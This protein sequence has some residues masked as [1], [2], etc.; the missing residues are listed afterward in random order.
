ML[1]KYIAQIML[2]TICL[3]YT[4]Y[5]KYLELIYCA[6]DYVNVKIS[7]LER[8]KIKLLEFYQ[9]FDEFIST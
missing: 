5:Q 9:F 7:L 3:I 1:Q 6:N 2:L 4:I 8:F